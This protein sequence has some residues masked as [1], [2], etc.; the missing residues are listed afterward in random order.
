MKTVD[1]LL[2]LLTLEEKVALVSG[3]KFMRTNPIPRLDIPSIKTSDGP[4]G[5]R[6]QPDGGDN[7]VTNSLPATCFPTASCSANTWRPE[8]LKKMGK[9]M[10]EEAKYYGVSVILGPG[11]NIKRNPRC[12]R[13]FEYFS[14]DPF[15][16]GR[17]G[18]KEV[19]G[20]QGEGIGV[21]L[22]HFACNNSENYRFMGNSFVDMRTMR[23][24][25][26]RQF[27]YIVKTVKPETLMGSYC[28][29]NGIYCCE[30]DW[31][32]N[33][34]LRDE[35]G[36]EG[37]VMSDW[38]ATHNRVQGV[39]AGLDL[40]MPGDTDI[41]R[42]WLSDAA[43][44]GTLDIKDLDKAVRNVLNL[45]Y[46]HQ[47]IEKDYKVDWEAHNELAKE[48]ATEGAVLL[49]NEGS[50]P[51]D[52]KESILIIG[53]LFE[54]SRYQGAGSSL[55]NPY[56]HSSPKNAFDRHNIN[57][58][59]VRG[60]RVGDLKAD[61]ELIKEAM[62]ATN[63]YDKVILFCGLTD[64]YE[65]EGM[66]RENISLPENQLALIDEL[67]KQN[68]KIIAIM[69]GG[70]VVEIPFY[71]DVDSMLNMFLSGQNLGEATYELMFGKKNPSGKLSETW[72]MKY[73]DVPFH[74]EFSAER[75]EVY[76]ES[77]YVGYRYY[78]TAAKEVR[79]PFG[80]GLS[81]TTFEYKNLKVKQKEKELI[82][83]VD[84]TN[85]G[86][87]EGAEVV[88]IYITA[89]Q[90][91]T[92]KALRELKGFD[93]VDLK[94]QETKT[95]TVQILKEDLKYW[96]LKED[97]FVLEDGDYEVQAG[98]NSKDIVLR[99]NVSIK[100]EKVEEKPQKAYEILNFEQ[101]SNEVYEA[102][103]DVKIPALPS[104]K[105]FTLESRLSDLKTSFMGKILYNALQS[106]PK[107][108]MKKA[109]K[110][111][112]GIEKEN[113]LK[114]A[115]MLTVILDSNS[116]ISLSMCSSGGFPYNFAC[117]FRD[118]AN[119]HLFKGIGQFM[120]KI[121]APELPINMKEGK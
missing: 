55:I 60:Y 14:E 103:W 64:R 19:E 81:Y 76:K 120:K 39:Q 82:V 105:P 51:L 71:D 83:S 118:L 68:K 117:G 100:G 99:Q 36:F 54:K 56:H 44:N 86:K 109:L 26:L 75:Q 35:W 42:K 106:V 74:D 94:P 101:L 108:E 53:E 50:L 52:E 15:L 67:V 1:E 16:A 43:N 29:A 70:S 69:F 34:V 10:A 45:V 2:P 73:E 96:S 63:Q 12:G 92:H 97:R 4:H 20:I 85:T 23:E 110:M 9:A 57:Y 59:Y 30:N 41:T 18:A 111:P 25:Y 112:D 46:K 37:L 119:G 87:V 13:N 115:E 91:N 102:N 79:F 104:K 66:D 114:G 6:A 116:I 40:E 89:P 93:K 24:I 113:K 90:N 77:I 65:C 28:K 22:K 3:Y 21:S 33:K 5:L 31:L 121:K 32:L 72:P 84:V 49:K 95:V 47:N 98:K 58:K 27:E 48:I 78:L 11:V 7:G 61:E 38:G 17:M 62:E 8:L 80:Y 88:E 107:K